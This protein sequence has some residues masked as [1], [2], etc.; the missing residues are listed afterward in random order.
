MNPNID[1]L[2]ILKSGEKIKCNFTKTSVSFIME[3]VAQNKPDNCITISNGGEVT[4]IIKV[5]EIAAVT[6]PE[7]PKSI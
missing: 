4:G 3:Q 7:V 2:F 5:S 1:L 6:T